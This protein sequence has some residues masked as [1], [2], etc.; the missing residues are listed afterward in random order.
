[1][2]CASMATELLATPDGSVRDQIRRSLE[3]L[4]VVEGQVFE[5]R[6]FEVPLKYGRS[7]KV[8]GF[9]DDLDKLAEDAARVDKAGAEG[10]YVT[11]NPLDPAL[12]CWADNILTQTKEGRAAR[13]GDIL[14]RAWILID[15]DP[16]RR[17]GTSATDT[18]VAYARDVARKVID[19]VPETLGRSCARPDQ[20]AFSGNG[21]HLLYRAD[22][23]NTAQ[24]TQQVK[25]YLE[26]LAKRCDD[27]HVSI[28]KTVYNPSRI[29]KL[30]GTVARKGC[31]VERLGRV[32]RRSHLVE[33]GVL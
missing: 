12:L 10:I 31:S 24:I 16:R 2:N 5:L 6:A 28:D 8:N 23:P 30:W 11:L 14:R 13:D 32:H 26:D 25:A 4:R 21:Y 1:M 19:A 9:Y 18:E 27:E 33:G 15:I 20:V 22:L 7:I 3:R 29:V 17:A